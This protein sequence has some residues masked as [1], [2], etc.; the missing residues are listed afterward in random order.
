[1]SQTET[2]TVGRL[3]T[4]T[5]DYLKKHGA[6]SPRLDA[7]VL[8]AHARGCQRIELYT[9][10]DVEVDEDHRATFR[11]YVRRR[12]AGEP[13]AYLV[14]FREFY[15]MPFKVTSDVLIP[16]PETEDLV[17]QTLDFLRQCAAP[18]GTLR[19]ADVGVGS[20]AIAVTLAAQCESCSLVATDLSEAAIA[21][22]R[23]NAETHNVA[24]RI[25][26]IQCDLLEGVPA[27]PVFDAVVS[28]PPYVG[29]AEWEG[30][31]VDVKDNEPYAALVGGESGVETIARLA[32]QAAERLREGGWFL[33]E[34]SPMIESA[35]HQC[36]IDDGRFETPITIKDL[37]GLA[38][39]VKAKRK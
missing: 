2:W 3:L 35:V 21:V 5:T 27:E 20:G 1:M 32:P 19:V 10:Y 28:N 9:A 23:E 16:R 36:I 31:S 18:A 25:E 33:C 22:A 38:R 26:F 14:G 17:L 24:D 11:E 39:I 6:E 29:Q 7:E 37:A 15:S 30:L 4:W 8:L 13:V 34:M 12:A